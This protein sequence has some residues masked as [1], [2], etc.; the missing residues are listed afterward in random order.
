MSIVG[1]ISSA[2][3]GEHDDSSDS[4]EAGNFLTIHK[5]LKEYCYH[6]IC[7][8]T[9]VALISPPIYCLRHGISY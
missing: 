2:N 8:A 7:C 3:F 5:F 6:G 1:R 4:I 9:G